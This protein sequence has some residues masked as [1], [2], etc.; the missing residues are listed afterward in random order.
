MLHTASGGGR[1]KLGNGNNVVYYG[2]GIVYITL[3]RGVNTIFLSATTGVRSLNCGGNPQTQVFVNER[4]LG[5]Y[6]M[7]IFLREKAI[8]LPQ[9]LYL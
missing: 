5:P 8:E 9:R 7:Q 4:S 3:G 2:S 6:S 1:F